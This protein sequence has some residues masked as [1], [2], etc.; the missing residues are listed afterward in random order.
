MDDEPRIKVKNCTF[1]NNVG[2]RGSAINWTGGALIISG[3]TFEEN[4]NTVTATKIGGAVYF[5]YNLDTQ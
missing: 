1:R 3:S 2:R 5:Y 4:H